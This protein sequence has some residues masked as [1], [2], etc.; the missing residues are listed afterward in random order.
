[1]LRSRLEPFASH[2]SLCQLVQCQMSNW[3]II[4]ELAASSDTIEI[5]QLGGAVCFRRAFVIVKFFRP[6]AGVVLPI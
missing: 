1:V 6:L 4:C 5:G 3:G 2:I